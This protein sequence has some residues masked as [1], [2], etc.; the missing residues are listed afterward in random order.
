MDGLLAPVLIS[1]SRDIDCQ[2]VTAQL[3]CITVALFL[4]YSSVLHNGH[5]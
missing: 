5:Q 2:P 4:V 3:Q 1:A